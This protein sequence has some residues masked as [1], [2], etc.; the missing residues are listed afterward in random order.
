MQQKDRDFIIKSVNKLLK[1]KVAILTQAEISR[2]KGL[3]RKIGTG[4]SL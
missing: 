4:H 3:L 2:L 1:V